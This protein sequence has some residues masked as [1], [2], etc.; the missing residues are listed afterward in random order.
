MI[1][2]YGRFSRWFDAECGT[3]ERGVVTTAGPF[4][5]TLLSYGKTYGPVNTLESH[6]LTKR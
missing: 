2:S 3:G 1:R 6:S 5:T 4:R